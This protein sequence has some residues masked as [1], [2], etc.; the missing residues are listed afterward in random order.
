MPAPDLSTAV[1]LNVSDFKEMIQ[2]VSFAAS[3][4]EARP[5]LQ[6]VMMEINENR[7]HWQPLMASALRCAAQRSPAQ[8]PIRLKS[9][10]RRVR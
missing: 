9:S 3:T 4:D 5:V 6:G 2:Q 7:F 8:S 10:F 1:E